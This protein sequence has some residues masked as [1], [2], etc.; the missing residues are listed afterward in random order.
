MICIEDI[1]PPPWRS[2]ITLPCDCE[3]RLNNCETPHH[4]II[5]SKEK[6]N[7]KPYNHCLRAVPLTSKKDKTGKVKPWALDYGID[8]SIDDIDG[9]SPLDG[10]PTVA[11]IDRICAIDRREIAI[12]VPLEDISKVTKSKTQEITDRIFKLIEIRK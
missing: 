3:G 2:L 4:F 11:L 6:Y 7:K 9:E 10:K 1:T 12:P 8:I 5:I